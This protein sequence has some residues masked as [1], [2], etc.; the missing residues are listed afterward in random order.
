MPTK[1]I[2]D[3]VLNAL[4]KL[5]CDVAQV[6]PVHQLQGDLGVDSTELVELAALVRTDCGIALQQVELRGARTVSDLTNLIEA[7]IS[8]QDAH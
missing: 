1:Q 5:G 7:A 3:A 4:R 2:E 6:L 8:R